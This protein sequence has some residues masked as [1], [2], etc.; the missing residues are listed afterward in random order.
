MLEVNKE[1]T[2]GINYHI[3][4]GNYIGGQE[5]QALGVA[6]TKITASAPVT[7]GQLLELTA[8]WK[9]APATA[10]STKFVGIAFNSADINGEVTVDTEGLMKLKTSGAVAFGDTL[11]CGADGT[12]AKLVDTG[13]VVGKA[14][15]SGADATYVY[16]KLR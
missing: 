6:Q 12:V 10:K 11:V 14:F 16:V 2:M 3:N 15:T 4:E 5:A 8:D 7:K 13:D 9:V 1:A